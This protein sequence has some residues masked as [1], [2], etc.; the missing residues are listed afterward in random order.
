[1]HVIN[2]KKGSR[3][4]SLIELVIAM[5]V[6][7]VIMGMATTLI[8]GALR[9]RSRENQKSDALAD[10]QRAINIMSREIASAGFNLYPRMGI[11]AAES[12]LHQIRIRS[13]LNKF[14]F[15]PEVSDASRLSVLDEGEDV[16]YLISAADNTN[17]LA[18]HDLHGNGKT[19]LANRLDSFNIHYFDQRVT[20][21][22]P[23]VPSPW[24]NPEATDISNPSAAEV[25]T[26]DLAK[27]V[28]IA[29]SVTLNAQGTPGSAGYQPP[30]R[31]LLCSDVALRNANLPNY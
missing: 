2:N 4:F 20:Y 16:T 14:D 29:V 27:Y 3:G 30:Y 12:G 15:R 13:N 5:A 25:A 7:L 17:Y 28:V 19:V 6:T 23:L 10:A 9:I 26:P 31:V 24:T 18:R 1:M 11:V 22:C 21:T 8:A